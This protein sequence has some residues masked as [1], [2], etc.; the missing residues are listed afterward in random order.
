MIYIYL[1]TVRGFCSF[2]RVLFIMF[3]VLYYNNNRNY[4]RFYI[5]DLIDLSILAFV[6]CWLLTF[7]SFPCSAINRLLNC[8]YFCFKTIYIFSLYIYIF[9][10]YNY[11]SS[12]TIVCMLYTAYIFMYVAHITH[13]RDTIDICSL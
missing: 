10:L 6:F 2:L 12:Y 4:Y 3:V 9:F 7:S 5:I 13:R 11:T 8:S 1:F